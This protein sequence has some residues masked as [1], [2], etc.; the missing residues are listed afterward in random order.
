MATSTPKKF[1]SPKCQKT[2]SRK[3]VISHSTSPKSSPSRNSSDVAKRLRDC[4]GTW[5]EHM[6]RWSKLNELGTSLANKLVNLQLQKEWVKVICLLIH[7]K[8]NMNF[9]WRDNSPMLFSQL[10]YFSS[11]S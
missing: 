9:Y 5:H 2:P 1:K 4:C 6:R 11:F 3:E 10:Y 7:N 8:I